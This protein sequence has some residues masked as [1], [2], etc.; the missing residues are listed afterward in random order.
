MGTAGAITACSAGRLRCHLGRIWRRSLWPI[1]RY[2]RMVQVPSNIHSHRLLYVQSR[3]TE[4]SA[5][6][7]LWQ[8]LVLINWQHLFPENLGYFGKRWISISASAAPPNVFFRSGSDA[9]A[10]VLPR[11]P[12]LSGDL[13]RRLLPVVPGA[14]T[15]GAG[16]GHLRPLTSPVDGAFC[17]RRGGGA[18]NCRDVCRTTPRWADPTGI[19]RS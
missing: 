15:G 16:P 19:E 6:V 14:M 2:G 7:R 4:L 5:V 9:L 11:T 13:R 3:W 8:P 18:S 17:A 10:L 12:C 1:R